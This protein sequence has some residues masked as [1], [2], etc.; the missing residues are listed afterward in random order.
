[1]TVAGS[2]GSSARPMADRHAG[3]YSTQAS[4]Q[5]G[6]DTPQEPVAAGALGGKSFQVMGMQKSAKE[7]APEAP[8]DDFGSQTGRPRLVTP[9]VNSG[10]CR[11][12]SPATARQRHS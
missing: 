8:P 5:Q 1:M 3:S 6:V 4:P 2:E 12:P 10:Q 9:A 7:Q 11:R